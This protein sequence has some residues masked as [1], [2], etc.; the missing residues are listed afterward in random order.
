MLGTDGLPDQRARHHGCP[1]GRWARF[2]SVSGSQVR[3]G[4]VSKRPGGLSGAGNNGRQISSR[5]K[6]AKA[7]VVGVIAEVSAQRAFAGQRK[8]DLQ[9][10]ADVDLMGEIGEI[11]EIKGDAGTDTLSA[12]GG[13]HLSDHWRIRSS[14]LTYDEMRT[15]L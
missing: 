14:P 3:I 11:G 13:H 9:G 5:S 6:A 12:R 10:V 8:Q 2:H 7:L 4:L 15:Y 1:L